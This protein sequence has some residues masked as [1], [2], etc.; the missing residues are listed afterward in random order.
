VVFPLGI[1]HPDH[2]LVSDACMSLVRAHRDILWFC[3]KD[4]PSRGDAP[5]LLSDRLQ[6]LHEAKLSARSAALPSGE[7]DGKRVAMSAY[8]SQ[9][10]ALGTRLDHVYD[11]EQYWE[12]SA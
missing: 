5:T 2:R 1:E 11:P 6:Q 10:A 8:K 9:F 12:V 7:I 4:A 3:C